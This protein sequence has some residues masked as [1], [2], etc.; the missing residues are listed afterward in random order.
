MPDAMP[1]RMSTAGG[2]IFGP[3][4]YRAGKKT[5]CARIL[6]LELP[7]EETEQMLMKAVFAFAVDQKSDRIIPYCICHGIH[8]MFAV[9][10]ILR[11]C[12]RRWGSC[13]C[14]GEEQVP[15]AAEK[16]GASASLCPL[17]GVPPATFLFHGF[18]GDSCR[19]DGERRHVD[20][21]TR[22]CFVYAGSVLRCRAVLP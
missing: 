17:E 6:A 20:E 9:N 12:G 10:A 7:F 22:L 11:S 15:D 2:E 14:T 13:S 3:S 21:L 18:S 4:G 16:G 8:D 19:G 1:G 5:V